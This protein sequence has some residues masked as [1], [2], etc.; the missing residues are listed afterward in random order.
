LRL[1][2]VSFILFIF[3]LVEGTIFQ[4]FVPDAWGLPFTIVPRLV[5]IGVIFIGIY[6]GKNT[7]LVYGLIFGLLY[8]IIYTDMIGVYTLTMGLMG[9]MAGIAARY[10]HQTLL[11]TSVTIFILTTF[12]E[13]LAYGFYELF[14]LSNMTMSD[15]LLR[16]LLPTVLF[17][18]IFGMIIHLPMRRLLKERDY[19]DDIV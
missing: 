18:G 19:K 7:G 1:S 15:F 10:F 2:V 5:L 4:V 13:C 11:F 9:F 6:L 3:L 17:N 16:E 14:R 8:D 12:N